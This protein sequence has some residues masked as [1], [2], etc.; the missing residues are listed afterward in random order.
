MNGYDNFT[1]TIENCYKETDNGELSSLSILLTPMELLK[2]DE[3]FA[4]AK[5]YQIDSGETELDIVHD[6]F[7]ENDHNRTLGSGDKSQTK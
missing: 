1:Q 5:L 3:R 4:R 2:S 7:N 6:R